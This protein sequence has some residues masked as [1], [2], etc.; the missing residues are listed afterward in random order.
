[1]NLVKSPLSSYIYTQR[2]GYTAAAG[3]ADMRDETPVVDTTFLTETNGVLETLMQKEQ[4]PRFLK[5]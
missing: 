1:M 2:S 4:E 3:D 5:A